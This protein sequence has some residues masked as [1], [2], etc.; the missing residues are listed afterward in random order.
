MIRKLLRLRSNRMPLRTR[1]TRRLLRKLRTLLNR[2][3][4]MSRSRKMIRK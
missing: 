2:R 4:M 1:N 3:M